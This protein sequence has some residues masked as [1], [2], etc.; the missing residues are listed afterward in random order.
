MIMISF[1][2]RLTNVKAGPLFKIYRLEVM[3]YETNDTFIV[4]VNALTHSMICIHNHSHKEFDVPIHTVKLTG[5][6]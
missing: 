2:T 5:E 4:Y 6:G 3:I 1:L